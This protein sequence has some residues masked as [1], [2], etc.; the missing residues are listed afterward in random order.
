MVPGDSAIDPK[1]CQETC[2]GE[3]LRQYIRE[4]H[5]YMIIWKPL[6]GEFL[7]YV[8]KS[9]NEVEKNTAAVICTNSHY[10]RRWFAMCNRIS[11]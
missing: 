1:A 5:V 4:S 6:V 2:V 8:K 9:T 11:P 10:K 3:D 7:Q